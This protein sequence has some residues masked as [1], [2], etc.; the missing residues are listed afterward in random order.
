MWGEVASRAE[1]SS[2]TTSPY[3]PPAAGTPKGRKSLAITGAGAPS[4]EDLKK[5]T[6]EKV[7]H[8]QGPDPKEKGWNK[9][10]KVLPQK[11]CFHFGKGIGCSGG[12]TQDGRGTLG[13]S[14]LPETRKLSGSSKK[15]EF[16]A[17][18]GGRRWQGKK[19]NPTR[20]KVKKPSSKQ[21]ETPRKTPMGTTISDLLGAC[22]RPRYILG[23]S[24]WG[25]EKYPLF[26]GYWKGK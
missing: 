19:T 13:R 18:K 8:S 2:L 10:K 15:K 7:A 3:R 21:K 23:I 5:T 12:G 20:G 25:K 11:G 24:K 16:Q 4:E 17:G 26:S 14:R 6:R 1:T 22:Q 9:T